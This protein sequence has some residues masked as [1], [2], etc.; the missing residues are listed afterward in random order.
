M[1]WVRQR[2]EAGQDRVVGVL[3]P[4]HEQDELEDGVRDVV[5]RANPIDELEPCA[6]EVRQERARARRQRAS[7]KMAM[8]PQEAQDSVEVLVEGV[9]REVE[10]AEAWKA[11]TKRGS[12]QLCSEVKLATR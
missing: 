8:G 10:S 3:A 1:R 12:A 7:L 4:G 9:D 6:C 5:W 11:G 2:V